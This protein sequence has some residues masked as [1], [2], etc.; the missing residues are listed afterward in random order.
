MELGNSKYP[1]RDINIAL[2]EIH[3]IYANTN[4]TVYIY[5]NEFTDNYIPIDYTYFVNISN[6][7]IDTY[8][9]INNTQNHTASLICKDTDIDVGRS[10]KSLFHIIQN[11][12]K[13]DIDTSG[14]DSVEGDEIQNAVDFAMI[15]NRSNMNINRINLIT[16]FENSNRIAG[17]LYTVFCY[18]NLLTVTNAFWHVQG[19]PYQNYIA[20][21]NV[22]AENITAD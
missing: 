5:I 9:T 20:S 22:F 2:N 16:D 7:Y 21:A 6:V 15:I 12:D 17:F 3:T 1:F 14:M 11:F 8:T 4:S 18:E 19:N 10:V 13:T